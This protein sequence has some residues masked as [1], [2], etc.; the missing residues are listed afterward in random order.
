LC[1]LCLNDFGDTHLKRRVGDGQGDCNWQRNPG[2]RKHLLRGS[3]AGL[4]GLQG[5]VT[6]P[7]NR[8]RDGPGCRHALTEIGNAQHC[9]GFNRADKGPAHP[10]IFKRRLSGVE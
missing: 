2:V 1:R 7:G 8:W 4:A 3:G 6:C 9:F 10:H 5:F